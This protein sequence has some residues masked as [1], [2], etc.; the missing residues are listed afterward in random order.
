MGERGR[1]GGGDRRNVFLLLPKL[2]QR[3]RLW[4]SCFL[5]LVC[6]VCVYVCRRYHRLVKLSPGDGT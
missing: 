3:C 2:R 5:M 1:E 6:F 4:L